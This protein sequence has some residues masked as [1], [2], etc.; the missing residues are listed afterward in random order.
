MGEGEKSQKSSKSNEQRDRRRRRR[1]IRKRGNSWHFDLLLPPSLP[2]LPRQWG[3]NNNPFHT[4]DACRE[5]LRRLIF[6]CECCLSKIC[7]GTQVLEHI[8]TVFLVSPLDNILWLLQAKPH[9][10]LPHQYWS[11]N[12]QLGFHDCFLCLNRNPSRLSQESML[13]LLNIFRQKIPRSL[14]AKY[15]YSF[16]S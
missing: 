7:K 12:R 4:K 13:V 10:S 15:V 5:M 11:P 1:P 9:V 16:S 14:Q 6:V 8:R 2:I 3:G